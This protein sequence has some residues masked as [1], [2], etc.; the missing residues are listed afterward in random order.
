[1]RLQV[2]VDAIA[3]DHNKY[4]KLR[5]AIGRLV[6]KPKR[7]AWVQVPALARWLASLEP[8]Q[9]TQHYVTRYAAPPETLLFAS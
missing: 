3:C 7:G 5:Q 9:G 4:I 2:I 8:T 1:V 6:L